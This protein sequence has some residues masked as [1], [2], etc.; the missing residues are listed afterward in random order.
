MTQAVVLT[1]DGEEWN[2]RLGELVPSSTEDDRRFAGIFAVFGYMD[3]LVDI[4][5]SDAEEFLAG[6]NE[7]VREMR[8]RYPWVYE[9]TLTDSATALLGPSSSERAEGSLYNTTRLL[10]G[11]VQG[12][13]QRITTL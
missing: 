2:S 3:L 6:L 4:E 11:T 7:H 1:A 8:I 9:R 10:E 12:V 5:R 13:F